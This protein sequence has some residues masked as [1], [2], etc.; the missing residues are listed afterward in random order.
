MKTCTDNEELKGDIKGYEDRT[1]SYSGCLSSNKE[2]LR[3]KYYGT[4]NKTTDSEKASS[5]GEWREKEE[6][7]Q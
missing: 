5:R 1:T 3:K 7:E 4:M 6:K 2:A